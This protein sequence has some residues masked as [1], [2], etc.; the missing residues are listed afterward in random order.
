MKSKSIV[1]MMAMVLGAAGFSFAQADNQGME[2]KKKMEVPVL[3]EM[4]EM[5]VVPVV[6]EMDEMVEAP[7]MEEMD[8]MDEMEE[9]PVVEEMDEMEEAPAME[10]MDEMMDEDSEMEEMGEMDEPA[11]IEVGNKICP[12]SGAKIGSMGEAVKVEYNGMIYNLCCPGC[13]DAF[14]AD[15]E[16]SIQKINEQMEMEAEQAEE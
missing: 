13:A 10:E 7:V 15:P 5:E 3:E 8:E 1:V 14:Y 2:M 9:V 16:A 4:D 12:I 6:E 11:L